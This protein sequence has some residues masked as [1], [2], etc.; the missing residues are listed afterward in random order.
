MLSENIGKIVMKRETRIIIIKS[1][2][3]LV[4]VWIADKPAIKLTVKFSFAEGE[5]E[6]DV[7]GR[8]IFD[9]QAGYLLTKL[10]EISQFLA[11]PGTIGKSE[12]GQTLNTVL[13]YLDGICLPP[14]NSVVAS[15]RT[16][17]REIAPKTVTNRTV[18][19][20]LATQ[21]GTKIR[22]MPGVQRTL[23]SAT[24]DWRVRDD[25]GG[26]F[27][28]WLKYAT[29]R[30]TEGLSVDLAMRSDSHQ[31]TEWSSCFNMRTIKSKNIKHLKSET[32]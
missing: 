32:V 10:R 1:R 11:Q 16:V 19:E 4:L 7:N 8:I 18:I 26:E 13:I 27:S 20:I 2:T 3:V 25:V 17:K 9:Q 12:I 30:H 24:K 31:A 28:R 21:F 6:T 14:G 23:T 29:R 22:E 15:Y 5:T